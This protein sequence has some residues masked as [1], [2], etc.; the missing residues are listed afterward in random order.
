MA[1]KTD[2]PTTSGRELAIIF[3]LVYILNAVVIYLAHLILPHQIVLGAK[4]IP[5]LWALKQSAIYTAILDM[6]AIPVMEY[7]QQLQGKVLTSN[8]WMIAYLIVN[9][10]GLWALSR[11]SNLIG[12]GISAWWVVLILAAILDFL[13]GAVIMATMKVVKK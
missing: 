2:L 4:D 12:L 9:F 8:A 5:L 7:V 3:I 11:Y 6:L 10:A 13:Q 1:K